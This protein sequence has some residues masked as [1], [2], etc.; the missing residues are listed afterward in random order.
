VDAVLQGR[1]PTVED[2]P[3]LCYTEMVIAESMR[4]YPPAWAMGRYARDDFHLGDYFLPA[5]TTVLISQ[6]ITHR[7]SRYFPDP[8]RFDPNR[9]TSEAK[10]RR[11]K[12]TYFPF[13]AGVRQ[14]IGESFAWMEGVLLLVTLA[15]KWKLSLVPG[16]CVEPQPLITLRPKYGMLMQV[17]ER[18]RREIQF[19]ACRADV[20]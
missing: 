7:D 18:A 13:G 1:L 19:P 15:Q 8:L 20:T 2:V 9:F 5:K 12:F 10:S 6:F 17:G 4:L 16:H 11:T 14:C 3:R